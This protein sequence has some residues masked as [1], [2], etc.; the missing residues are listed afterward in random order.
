ML[1]D[2][3]EE[4]MDSEEERTII[5]SDNESEPARRNSGP[6]RAMQGR[7]ERLRGVLS[8]SSRETAAGTSTA[9]KTKCGSPCREPW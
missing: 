2:H 4:E 6:R 1:A 8:T 3:D 9:R 5:P 7:I